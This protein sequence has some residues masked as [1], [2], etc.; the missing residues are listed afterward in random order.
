MRAYARKHGITLLSTREMTSPW[1]RGRRG[2]WYVVVQMLLF[3]LVAAGPRT[4]RGWPDWP[5]PGGPLVSIGGWALMVCGA[6]LAVSGL[7]E[8]G[9]SRLS[10]LPYPRPG[11]VLRKTGAFAMVRHP[12]YGGA[13]LAAFGWALVRHGWLT[14][15]YAVLLFIFFDLKSCREEAWLRERFPEYAE[16]ARR[17]RKLIP[18]VY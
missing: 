12:M 14:C 18:F 11:A 17:V 4:W 9:W 3:A 16:Y 1:W 2:E 15:G 10:A 7:V 13:I 6:L 5:F 8:M